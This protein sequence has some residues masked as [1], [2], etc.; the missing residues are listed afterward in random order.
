[1]KKDG[2]ESS[3]GLNRSLVDRESLTAAGIGFIAGS[4]AKS[5]AMEIF[6][7]QELAHHT[8]RVK[9]WLNKTSRVVLAAYGLSANKFALRH[10][11]HHRIDHID[12]RESIIGGVAGAFISSGTREEALAPSDPLA[13]DWSG[14]DVFDDPLTTIESGEKVLRHNPW[15][16]RLASKGGF[17]AAILPALGCASI[18]AAA[19]MVGAKKP[20][21]ATTAFVGASLVPLG[22]QPGV[23]SYAEA[24]A[25]ISDG[26]I[27]TDRVRGPLRVKVERHDEHHEKPWRYDLGITP[28]D[29]LAIKV[30]MALH[31]IEET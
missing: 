16:E 27:N 3:L 4:V 6:S 11:K 28:V 22:L 1:M 25:G 9:P 12:S 23:T 29:R 8:L 20:A 21:V 26:R 7:H 31:Q 10:R 5:V 14:E 2:T 19:R 24:R 13:R 17:G 30:G 15:Y 18:Y